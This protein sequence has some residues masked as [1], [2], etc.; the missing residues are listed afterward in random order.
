MGHDLLGHAFTFGKI[1]IAYAIAETRKFFAF[2]RVRI[3]ILD[4]GL[5]QNLESNVG[6]ESSEPSRSE[7]GDSLINV[8]V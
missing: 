5:F 2:F 7:N 4:K 6:K 1:A 3:R 8:R